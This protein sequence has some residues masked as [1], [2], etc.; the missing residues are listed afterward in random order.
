[1][2]RS[3]SAPAARIN[4]KESLRRAI[5]LP[6]KKVGHALEDW[7]ADQSPMGNSSIIDAKHFEWVE[8]LEKGS[9]VIR[10]ELVALLHGQKQLPNIQ[11]LNPRQTNLGQ[12]GGWKSYFFCL[13]GNRIDESYKRCPETG[14]LL[15]SIPGLTLAFFSILEPGMHIKAHRG[16]YKGVVRCHLG[17]IVPEPQTNVRMRVGNEMVYWQEGKCV[18]FDDTHKHEVWNDTDGIRVVLLFDVYR[19]LPR[20]LTLVNKRVL[21]LAGYSPEA[22][23]LVR[24]QREWEMRSPAP[25]IPHQALQ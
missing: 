12:K 11:E 16:G 5:K 9:D 17:L 22:R 13:F 10:Q 18:I 14:K 19:P 7:V 15:D 8:R 1:V 3:A 2:S 24:S 23:R 6:L 21:N 4:L 20:W 25:N